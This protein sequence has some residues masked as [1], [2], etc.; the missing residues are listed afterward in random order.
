MSVC[1]S[2]DCP[3]FCYCARAKS[4]V[5]KIEDCIDW[6]NYGSC[7]YSDAGAGK[8][9]YCCGPDGS[10]KMFEPVESFA[11]VTIEEGI[12]P[13]AITIRCDEIVLTKG[14][15]KLEINCKLTPPL[16]QFEYIEINEVRFKKE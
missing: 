16:D 15:I 3:K 5:G 2:T 10:Y 7:S 6:A 11:G 4:K 8:V 13:N 1:I 12:R 9:E 14:C